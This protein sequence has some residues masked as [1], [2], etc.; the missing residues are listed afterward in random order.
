MFKIS[1]IP[2]LIFKIAHIIID[3]SK[4]LHYRSIANIDKTARII[5][6]GKII[7]IRKIKNTIQVGSNSIVR[8]ELLTFG[9]GGVISIGEWCYVGENSRIWSAQ[10]VE[11]G[12]RV[13]ISHNV[14]IHDTNGHPVNAESRHQDFI[15]ISRTGHPHESPDII[16]LPIKIEDDVW[17][18][19]NSTIL[20]GIT[21]GKGAIIGAS[22]V[23]TKDIPPGVTVVGNPAKV[24][25]KIV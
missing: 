22:S 3:Y 16:S 9:H 15:A 2:F 14:N 18:G 7:N 4:E 11:I 24:V 25:K 23:V 20:K 21:I 10:K 1:S 19:F 12:N 8:G 13:L 17:I 6:G 5:A